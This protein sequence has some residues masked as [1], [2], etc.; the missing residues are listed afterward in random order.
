MAK[1]A[2]LTM[3]ALLCA[4]FAFS[5]TIKYYRPVASHRVD[6]SQFP[7][8]KGEWTGHTLFIDRGILDMLNPDAIFNALYANNSGDEIDLFFS[9]FAGDNAQGGVH[10]PRNCMPGG[11]WV[12]LETQPRMIK[13]GNASVPASR[14]M[15][16]F[17][18]TVR[19]VDY[20]YITR[21]GETSSDYALKLY[22]MISALSFK[23]TDVSF[24][25]FIGNAD[26]DGLQQLDSFEQQ[27][28]QEVY[29]LLPFGQSASGM[30]TGRPAQLPAHQ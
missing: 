15:V 30:S 20:W 8:Q 18:K 16:R 23:P 9:Y 21:Y 10:S 19:A 11:G 6:V 5:A 4:T 26:P 13:V 12:I 25:R 14:M 17:G 24:V 2:F 22:T 27:F 7:L 1:K 28:A 3:L 29:R